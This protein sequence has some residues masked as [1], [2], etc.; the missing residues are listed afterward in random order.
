MYGSSHMEISELRTAGGGLLQTH[1]NLPPVGPPDTCDFTEG[2]PEHCLKAGDERVNEILNLAMMH[3]AFLREHNRLAKKVANSCR[4]YRRNNNRMFEETRRI[5]IGVMQNIVFYEFLPKVLGR[6]MMRR[7]GLLEEQYRGYDESVNPSILNEFATAAYRFGHSLVMDEF[8]FMTTDYSVETT[9]HVSQTF[10][11]PEEIQYTEQA[12]KLLRFLTTDR[13]F[14]M[15]REFNPAIQDLLFLDQNHD[16]F[17]LPAAN[18]QRGRDHGLAPY[19]EIRRA[20]RLPTVTTFENLYGISEDDRARLASVYAHVDDIDL[21]VGG[22]LEE[23][24]DGGIVGPTFA[25]II[26]EQFRRLKVGD[27]YYFER[28][29]ES[30]REFDRRQIAAIKEHSLAKILCENFDFQYIQRDVMKVPNCISNPTQLCSQL[31]DLDM[32]VFC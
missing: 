30:I 25:C 14:K 6:K 28:R 2:Q 20:C 23:H 22:I 8:E 17:D 19:M 7:N 26:G 24:V 9:K 31:P 27:R 18:T 29:K 4:R 11:K 16:S 5:M 1:N 15:D 3:T 13:T 10:F 32:N 12:K 21:F